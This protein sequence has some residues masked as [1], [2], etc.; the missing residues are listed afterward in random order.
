MANQPYK[1]KKAIKK[2]RDPFLNPDGSQVIFFKVPVTYQNWMS[3]LTHYEKDILIFFMTQVYYKKSL[4]IPASHPEIMHWTGIKTKKTV[5]VAIR[6]LAEKG[7]LADV[8]TVKFGK[9]EYIINL[10]PQINTNLISKL[11][12]RSRKA[13]KAK[14]KSIEN[15]ERGKFVTNKDIREEEVASNND[16]Y[17]EN[18]NEP[19][20]EING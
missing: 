7:W 6:G 14:K 4:R 9:N 18:R 17:G 10:E 12:L 11:E 15:G 1:K 2:R 3:T 13:S 5:I 16:E 8:I 20:L 19:I